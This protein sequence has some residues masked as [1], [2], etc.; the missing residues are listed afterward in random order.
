VA[1]TPEPTEVAGQDGDNVQSG[2]QSGSDTGEAA[3][4]ENEGAETP[5]SEAADA[6]ALASQ[7][8]ISQQQAEQAALAANPGTTVTH[9]S[10]GDEN[11]TIVYDVELSNGSDVKVDANSAAV[12]GTDQAGSDSSESE[13]TQGT[14]QP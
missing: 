14:S 9:S 8:H 7:A 2:D 11:G 1:G 4:A 12:I 13:G 3:G 6:Q 5:A 10:L